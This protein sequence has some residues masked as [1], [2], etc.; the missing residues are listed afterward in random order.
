MKLSNDLVRQTVA[1][2][3]EAKPEKRFKPGKICIR[4][5]DRTATPLAPRFRILSLARSGSAANRV[6]LR[7]FSS[8][9][10]TFSDSSYWLDGEQF[11]MPLPPGP[12][13]CSRAILCSVTRWEPVTSGVFR[14]NAQFVRVM[15][16][17]GNTSFPP[18][19][20]AARRKK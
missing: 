6:T 7:N 13:R 16:L 17:P 14:I 1:A 18:R 4:I 5:G 2:L 12:D 9:S 11:L 8:S 20:T 10:V 15:Q 3:N 19:R